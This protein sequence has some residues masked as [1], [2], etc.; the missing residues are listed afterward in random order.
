VSE[1]ESEVGG[2]GLVGGKEAVGWFS[3]GGAWT[4][5][6]RHGKEILVKPPQPAGSA[7]R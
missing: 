5:E 1:S 2:G 7:V 6:V 3:I 4:S